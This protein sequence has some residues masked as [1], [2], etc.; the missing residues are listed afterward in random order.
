MLLLWVYKFEAFCRVWYGSQRGLF[1]ESP[2]ITDSGLAGARRF[3]FAYD[4]TYTH[5]RAITMPNNR[6]HVCARDAFVLLILI[7]LGRNACIE[8]ECCFSWKRERT[9]VQPFGPVPVLV[10]M[11]LAVDWGFLGACGGLFSECRRSFWQM[12]LVIDTASFT[13]GE[14][15]WLLCLQGKGC[16]FAGDN[17]VSL[18][19]E[20][21]LE[22]RLLV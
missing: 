17:W 7:R 11:L 20:W 8:K 14:N 19:E 5:T 21:M 1:K 22:E 10:Q 12:W 18:E 2:G 13:A 6:F 15:W 16:L 3:P 9:N 4:C